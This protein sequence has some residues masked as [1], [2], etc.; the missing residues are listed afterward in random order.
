MAGS[1]A[2]SIPASFP[3]EPESPFRFARLGF[4]R[5][6][7]GSFFSRHFGKSANRKTGKWDRAGENVTPG[8]TALITLRQ[9]QSGGGNSCFRAFRT[10]LGDSLQVM[11]QGP[12]FAAPTPLLID[13][14]AVSCGIQQA[15][16]VGRTV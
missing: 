16:R 10:D 7:F 6:D 13:Q 8:R 4:I 11:E 9:R 12:I 2:P 5:H 14:F 15:F 3:K 1:A